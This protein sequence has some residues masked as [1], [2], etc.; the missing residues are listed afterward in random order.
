MYTV[1]KQLIFGAG[2]LDT[3]D[4]IRDSVDIIII[5]IRSSRSSRSRPGI[6]YRN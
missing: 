6:Q 2:V 3:S 4:D 1:H 5:T